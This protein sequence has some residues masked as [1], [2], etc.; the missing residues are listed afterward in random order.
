MNNRIKYDSIKDSVVSGL[1]EYINEEHLNI[2]QATGKVLEEDWR[3]VNYSLFTKSSYF[4]NIFIES[5]KWGE[6]ADFIYEK[7]NSIIIE[8]L[9]EVSK[10]EKELYMKDLDTYKQL[11]NSINYKVIE[12]SVS[13]KSRI[14]YLLSLKSV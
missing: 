5:L 7:M 9:E 14:D 2:S 3:E 4:L 8:D 12:T 1:D 6:V 13:T 11:R 10:E